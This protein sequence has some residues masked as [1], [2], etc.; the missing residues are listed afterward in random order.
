MCAFGT[1]FL[2]SPLLRNF[3]HLPS[4][5]HQQLQ[6]HSSPN[7][8]HILHLHVPLI[9]KTPFLSLLFKN[10]PDKFQDTALGLPMEQAGMIVAAAALVVLLAIPLVLCYMAFH[11]HR[12]RKRWRAE[13]KAATLRIKEKERRRA[14]HEQHAR[15]ERLEKHFSVSTAGDERRGRRGH[16]D[17]ERRGSRRGSRRDGGRRGESDGRETSRW[18]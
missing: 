7:V 2:A 4:D 15:R 9:N 5:E 8:H 3:L 16:R 1:C 10:M 12:E 14:L 17:E 18:T 11:T 13:N 6:H